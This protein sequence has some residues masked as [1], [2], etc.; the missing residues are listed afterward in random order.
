[1]RSAGSVRKSSCALCVSKIQLSRLCIL[2]TVVCPALI[3]LPDFFHSRPFA[4]LNTTQNSTS[5]P[6]KIKLNFENRPCFEFSCRD[7]LN[8]A[9]D[10]L[11]ELKVY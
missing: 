3:L 7:V 2:P 5:V 10:G 4:S 6:N 11:K 1:M 9:K 8:M